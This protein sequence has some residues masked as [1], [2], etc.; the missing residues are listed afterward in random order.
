M[1]KKY[2]LFTLFLISVKKDFLGMNFGFKKAGPGKKMSW[3]Q[4]ET[5]SKEN[6][7]SI[8]IISIIN[9]DFL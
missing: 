3:I 8:L 1:N 5:L 6:D 9:I 2:F 7:Y 4:S